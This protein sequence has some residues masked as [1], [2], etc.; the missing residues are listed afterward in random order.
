MVDSAKPHDAAKLAELARQLRQSAS[1]TCDDNYIDLF[2]RTAEALEARARDMQ[3]ECNTSQEARS[4]GGIDLQKP[5]RT[6]IWK[7]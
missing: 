6:P 5:F 4:G 1:Q 3:A 7:R 2:L